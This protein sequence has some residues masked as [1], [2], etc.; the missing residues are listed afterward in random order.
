M[1]PLPGGPRRLGVLCSAYGRGLMVWWRRLDLGG[2]WNLSMERYLRRAA[3]LHHV[4]SNLGMAPF[5]RIRKRVNFILR[6]SL[7]LDGSSAP[8]STC[9]RRGAAVLEAHLHAPSS[10]IGGVSGLSD[11]RSV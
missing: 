3:E 2:G 6:V 9:L 10:E 1:Q 7:G 5:V 8:P 11:S 4:A